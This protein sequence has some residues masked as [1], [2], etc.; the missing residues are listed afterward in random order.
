MLVIAEIRGER[1]DDS[2]DSR[3]ASSCFRVSRPRRG[4]STAFTTDPT[5]DGARESMRLLVRQVMHRKVRSVPTNLQYRFSGRPVH[6]GWN[7]VWQ[8]SHRTPF[9]THG[10]SPACH[11]DQSLKPAKPE[12]PLDSS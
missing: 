2:L 3:E 1:D 4:L 11:R 6:P 7:Q 5:G 12:S 8:L 10:G 9:F